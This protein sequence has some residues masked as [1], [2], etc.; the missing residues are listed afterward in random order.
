VSGDP[1]TYEPT[2][3]P[4]P[5][6]RTAGS[7]PVAPNPALAPS[8]AR[9]VYLIGRLRGRQITM[10][11]ATELFQI[12][13]QMIARVQAMAPPPSPFPTPPP[14]PPAMSGRT[15]A[16]TAPAASSDDLLWEALPVLAAGAGILAAVL[17]RAQAGPPEP[18]AATPPPASPA[19]PA[20]S[21][22]PEPSKDPPAPSS[23]PRGGNTASGR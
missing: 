20:P 9:Y 10:E 13:Q 4:A 8:P 15:Q 2:A 11:E 16:V 1:Y 14:P 7:P 18:K 23:R 6:P 17:K 19:S 12:Q 5:S 3:A 21:A 22:P